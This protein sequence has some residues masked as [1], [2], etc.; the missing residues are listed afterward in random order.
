MITLGHFH[1]LHSWVDHCIGKAFGLCPWENNHLSSDDKEVQEFLNNSVAFKT[2]IESIQKGEDKGWALVEKNYIPETI[3]ENI[4][5][6]IE[7]YKSSKY[8]HEQL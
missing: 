8:I 4:I 2:K 5:E 6:A 1:I 3:E 7:K